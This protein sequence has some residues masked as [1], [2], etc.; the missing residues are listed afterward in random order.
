MFQYLCATITE[1]NKKF[2]LIYS[3]VKQQR[4]VGAINSSTCVFQ[5]ILFWLLPIHI[6]HK[7]LFNA[8]RHAFHKIKMYI[9]LIN[10]DAP[11]GAYT[12]QYINPLALELDI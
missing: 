12:P 11:Q 8:T 1:N 7:L 6:A 9:T 5:L 3:S 4:K 2:Q 10:K